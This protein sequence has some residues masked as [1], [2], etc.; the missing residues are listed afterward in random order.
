MFVLICHNLDTGRKVVASEPLPLR[1]AESLLKAKSAIA[2]QYLIYWIE[3][4]E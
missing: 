1:A 3:A 2:Q 4:A